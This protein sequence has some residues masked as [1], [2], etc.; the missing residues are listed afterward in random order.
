MYLAKLRATVCLAYLFGYAV[1]AFYRTAW[2]G[3]RESVSAIW[4]VK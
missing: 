2:G 4:S 1:W 3:F